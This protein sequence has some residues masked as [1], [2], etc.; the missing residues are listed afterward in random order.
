VSA[1]RRIDC[2][3]NSPRNRP[4]LLATGANYCG[5]VPRPRITD[6]RRQQILE[7]AAAVIAERGI[8]DTRIADV[9][10]RIGSS[11]ALILYYFPSKDAL[12]IEALAHRDQQFFDHVAGGMD[13]SSGPVERLERLIEAS[14][15]PSEVVSDEDNEWHL[16]IET[17][18]RA[19][20][21]RGLAAERARMDAL[22][23]KTVADVVH[24]GITEGVFIHDDPEAFAL[25]LTCLIDGL[26]IQV[27][28]R[29][30]D[31][32][33]DV[34]R[35]LCLRTAR[36]ELRATSYELRASK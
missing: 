18:S 20:H 3:S 34:M 14:V 16:W 6:E 1:N 27:L 5:A 21:D 8:C 15:P 4:R 22:F 25:L 30:P 31:V 19:R 32:T 26:A 36:R 11:P 10:A 13:P 33:P 35:D 28:L 17:W 24:D 23:R 29:D 2:R 9:A 7:A 12:L